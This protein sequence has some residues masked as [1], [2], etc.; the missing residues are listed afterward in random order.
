MADLRHALWT[1]VR[2]DRVLENDILGVPLRSESRIPVYHGGYH[3][4]RDQAAAT[5]TVHYP[6]QLALQ[7]HVCVLKQERIARVAGTV[8]RASMASRVP[9]SHWGAAA[10]LAKTTCSGRG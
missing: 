9:S 2:K 10:R 8:S 1:H 3:P 7:V 4:A 6:I 5:E